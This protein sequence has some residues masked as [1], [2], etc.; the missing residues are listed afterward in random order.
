[1]KLILR[2]IEYAIATGGLF[3]MSGSLTSL[4]TPVGSETAPMVQVIGASL[5]LFGFIALLAT[6]GAVARILTLYWPAILPIMFAVASLVWSFAPDLT[7]RRAGALGLTTAFALWLAFRFTPKE[8]FRLVVLASA[9]IVL[10]NFTYIQINPT[11]GIHQPFDELSAQHAGSWRGFFGHKN[12]FG[13]AIAMTTSILLLGFIFGT[14]GRLGRWLILPVLG[15]SALMVV[16]ANSSQAVLL[17]ATVPFGMLVLLAMRRMS[18]IGRSLMILMALPV[19]VISAVS[20][21]LLFEYTL[22]LLGRDATLTGRTVIW[23]GVIIALGG[24]SVAGGGYGAG[25]IVVGPRLTALTGADVGHAHNGYLDLLTDVGYIGVGLTLMFILWLGALAFGNLMRNTRPE[26]SALALTVV[27]FSLIGNVAG[28][29]LLLHNS[30]YW[31]LLVATFAK[32]RDAPEI[33]FRAQRS[34][35]QGQPAMLEGAQAS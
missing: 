3:F 7:L 31:V 14:G 6:R 29:F 24:N 12:D 15:L 22:Q 25:W 11:R 16:N 13:R 34:M 35:R 27:L 28:S 18:P 33:Q 4:L 2:I 9:A 20:A 21:Q 5:G 19:A 10:A 8:L 26:V 1:M 17:T 23:E 32:L 30:I